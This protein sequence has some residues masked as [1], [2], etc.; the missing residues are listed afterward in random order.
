MKSI[1]VLRQTRNNIRRAT[2]NLSLDALN[3]IPPGFNNN[4]LWNIGHVV[5]TQQALM[6]RPC[7]MPMHVKDE[8]FESFRKGSEAT[9]YNQETLDYIW[10]HFDSL[11]DQ[12]DSDYTGKRFGEY[13]PYQTSYG[14]ALNNLEDAMVFNN[15]HEALHL[16]YIMA[17]K[18]ALN[19]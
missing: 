8:I 2:E 6:Y 19:A 3:T 13:K 1:D 16:G 7:G 9:S 10:D 5:V 12:L 14:L 11:V 15:A 18:R 17:Q 4:I